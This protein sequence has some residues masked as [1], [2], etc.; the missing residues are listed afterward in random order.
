MSISRFQASLL[1]LVLQMLLVSLALG[2]EPGVERYPN[3]HPPVPQQPSGPPQPARDRPG[4]G[5]TVGDEPPSGIDA[6][7]PEFVNIAD[8]E[9]FAPADISTYGA[10]IA[11]NTGWWFSWDYL[12]YTVT[13]PHRTLIGN[14]DIAPGY[15]T[16]SSVFY[17]STLLTSPDG[18]TGG[19]IAGPQLAPMDTGWIG[20]GPS[21]GYRW[22][23]GWMD[24]DH[25]FLLSAFRL[26]DNDQNAFANNVGVP[27]YAPPQGPYGISL[28][29]GFVDPNSR[30]F[31]ADLNGNGIFGRYGPNPSPG[32]V[33]S[34]AGAPDFGDLATLPVNFTSLIAYDH[35][36]LWGAEADY[37][38][39]LRP[40]FHPVT[41]EVLAGARYFRFDESF[42]VI[43][44]G[45]VLDSSYWNTRS[46]NN[47]GGG[48]IGLRFAHKRN[49]L[50]FTS[51]GRFAALANWQNNLQQGE[52]AS[53]TVGGGVATI[54]GR[55]LNLLP[56]GW[57]TAVQ[58]TEFSPLGELRF[59]LQYQVFNKASVNIG[60]TGIIVGN[61]ARP[62]DMINYQLPNM[63]LLVHG[64]NK[65]TV[66]MQGL[67]LGFIF[68][69]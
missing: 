48:Q 36:S 64:N 67:T 50:M 69:R 18:T 11:P 1:A 46:I 37:V 32:A 10:G 28:L 13:A 17:G 14:P 27:F 65:Q 22:E 52:I 60:W 12:R 53:N 56:T 8:M 62:A 68:N 20:Q 66:F 16:G 33:P 55:S 25:G 43:G 61:V 41:W 9:I 6:S 19:S 54:Q 59:N 51:E 21:N 63:G 42:A 2:I 31:D 44:Q 5:P 4:P 58:K 7:G 40:A 57:N 39:R 15:S 3:V 38:W 26:Y 45:G 34:N 24:R 30:G 49:R 23:G 29:Q 47:M 35:R